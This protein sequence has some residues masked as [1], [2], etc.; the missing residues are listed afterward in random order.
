MPGAPQGRVPAVQRWEPPE[1]PGC[2][3]SSPAGRGRAE[4]SGG[5]RSSRNERSGW[6]AAAGTVCHSGAVRA[7]QQ[8]RELTAPTAK[9]PRRNR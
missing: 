5:A 6:G 7:V 3:T 8:Q 4:R 2:G 1:A 9:S